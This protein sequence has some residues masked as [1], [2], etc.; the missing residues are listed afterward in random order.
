M[1]PVFNPPGDNQATKKTFSVF[2]VDDDQT[3][4]TA[5]GFRLMKE[6]KVNGIKVF[7]Y[8]SGEECLRNMDLNPSVII[9]D[10]HLAT[11]DSGAINGLEV[12]RR[13]KEVNKDVPVVIV[14]GQSNMD[15]AIEIYEEGAHSYIVKN[16]HA[17]AEIEK[18]IEELALKNKE[19]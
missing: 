12:L 10:H 7:C 2:I 16:K 17:L 6:S 15:I 14:S 13:I 11:A 19:Q 4:L 9:L 5:L 8:S 18:V 1:N 3:Y